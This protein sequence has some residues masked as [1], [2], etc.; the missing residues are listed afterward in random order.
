MNQLATIPVAADPGC[1]ALLRTGGQAF[2][3]LLRTSTKTLVCAQSTGEVLPIEANGEAIRGFT[4]AA[5]PG[6]A[7]EE[8][9]LVYIAQHTVAF[10]HPPT[11][12]TRKTKGSPGTLYAVHDLENPPTLVVAGEGYVLVAMG[13]VIEGYQIPDAPSLTTPLKQA[14]WVTTGDLVT[15]MG[16]LEARDTRP[17]YVVVSHDKYIRHFIGD[18][19]EA[20][21]RL[22]ALPRRIS[23]QGRF[24]LAC[25]RD[26]CWLIHAACGRLVVLHKHSPVIDA[27]LLWKPSTPIPRP[28][29]LITK[30]EEDWFRGLRDE[31]LERI[32]RF[33]PTDVVPL[34]AILSPT[35]LKVCAFTLRPVGTKD[36]LTLTSLQSRPYSDTEGNIFVGPSTSTSSSQV[37]WI[38]TGGLLTIYLISSI[39]LL[40]SLQNPSE[41]QLASP[42]AHPTSQSTLIDQFGTLAER[43]SNAIRQ[44]LHSLSTT[45]RGRDEYSFDDLKTNLNIKEDGSCLREYTFTGRAGLLSLDLELTDS[46]FVHSVLIRSPSGPEFHIPM[47]SIEKITQE[48]CKR[49]TGTGMD[50]LL[51]KTIRD[52]NSSAAGELRSLAEVLR[53]EHCLITGE[54]VS[55]VWGLL[56]QSSF[57]QT[58]FLAHASLIRQGV[59]DS[60]STF[61]KFLSQPLAYIPPKE[62]ESINQL[63]IPLPLAHCHPNDEL[64]ISII[65]TLGNPTFASSGAA[66]HV[67]VIT[68]LFPEFTLA[69]PPEAIRTVLASGASLTLDLGFASKDIGILQRYLQK[70]RLFV[71]GGAATGTSLENCYLRC[72][73]PSRIFSILLE[74]EGLCPEVQGA[75]DTLLLCTTLS[76]R[77]V[78]DANDE[79]RIQVQ[80]IDPSLL[81]LVYRRLIGALKAAGCPSDIVTHLTLGKATRELIMKMSRLHAEGLDRLTQQRAEL[82]IA[83]D[84]ARYSCGRTIDWVEICHYRHASQ[85]LTELRS[86]LKGAFDELARIQQERRT[87]RTASEYLED[88][89]NGL[90]LIKQDATGLTQG[91]FAD[92]PKLVQLEW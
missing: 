42:S 38:L 64:D 22:P 62:S 77:C 70:G 75:R 46:F 84:K 47:C 27:V 72:M 17:E 57:A 61:Y 89:L 39:D 12:S 60:D 5:R 1:S 91:I 10:N 24:I 63:S 67:S 66:I 26:A 18:E 58:A 20:E 19:L 80:C 9:L 50:L 41:T 8:D 32:L 7:S 30:E 52:H 11:T 40:T 83:T 92:D 73:I 79:C 37:L 85:S 56:T 49:L 82:V 78:S 23:T 33:D 21:L 25:I 48:F 4:A 76:F 15:H 14:F 2:S 87:A 90:A 65:C 54:L 81:P 68:P 35:A 16:C 86:D 53:Q 43:R 36:T 13:G 6:A 69:H 31:P 3:V 44:H 28:S 88:L 29:E 71:S 45:G 55:D 59:E 34:I 51:G 74:N